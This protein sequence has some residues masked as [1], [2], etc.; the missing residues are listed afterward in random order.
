[1]ITRSE[2]R[3]DV[4]SSSVNGCYAPKPA[5][6]MLRFTVWG[7]LLLTQSSRSPLHRYMQ[8]CDMFVVNIQLGES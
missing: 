1:M 7:G 5:I 2:F 4:H 6:Q 8:K 3:G